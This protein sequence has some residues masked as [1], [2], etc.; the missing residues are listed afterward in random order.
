MQQICLSHQQDHGHTDG[1]ACSTARQSSA[2]DLQSSLEP[3]PR[4]LGSLE[5]VKSATAAALQ[6]SLAPEEGMH[7]DQPE[8]I[9]V[10]PELLFQKATK[11]FSPG[12][13]FNSL[14]LQRF[15]KLLMSS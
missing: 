14:S 1:I 2:A 9:D 11:I 15:V 6:Q 5:A 7:F 10:R 12:R 3:A 4:G 13:L 8:G